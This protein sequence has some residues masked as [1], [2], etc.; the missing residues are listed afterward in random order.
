MSL[1]VRGV[2][3]P[4]VPAWSPGG[5]RAAGAGR[6]ASRRPGGTVTL[7]ERSPQPR[8]TREQIRAARHAPL[9]P[10]LQRH[11]LDLIELGA[12]NFE[13]TENPGLIIKD[14][15][16]NWP[17]RELS[18]NTIDFAMQILG[19]TFH[20]AMTEISSRITITAWLFSHKVR[21]QSG[22]PPK[23]HTTSLRPKLRRQLSA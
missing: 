23:I 16:W 6:K 19:L 4:R 10:L 7:S 21:P 3:P 11:Q 15:Y 12:G 14:A 2:V 8:W 13:P 5:V 17:E 22:H 18:G 9:L 1:R 20:Q